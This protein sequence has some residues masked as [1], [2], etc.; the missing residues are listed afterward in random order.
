MTRKQKKLH[1]LAQGKYL[2]RIRSERRKAGICW[3]CGGRVAVK[4][5]RDGTEKRLKTCEAYLIQLSVNK[6]GKACHG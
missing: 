6:K 3:H 5:M 2:A 1:A 4:L